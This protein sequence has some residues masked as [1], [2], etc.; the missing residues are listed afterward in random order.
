MDSWTLF[1]NHH[2]LKA[3]APSSEPLRVRVSLSGSRRTCGPHGGA[4]MTEPRYLIIV[5]RFMRAAP[6]GVVTAVL[7]T[8]L[9]AVRT[10]S[11]ASRPLLA[12]GLGQRARRQSPCKMQAVCSVVGVFLCMAWASCVWH[13]LC[14]PVAFRCVRSY[15]R[16]AG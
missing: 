2:N 9:V 15:E 4:R 12:P 6:P 5:P 1:P 8:T 11:A 10:S 16:H 3:A 7:Y 13:G 14:T